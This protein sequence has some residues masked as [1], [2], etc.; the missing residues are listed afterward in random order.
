MKLRTDI[1]LPLL[2]SNA[3]RDY[4]FDM[5]VAQ[6]HNADVVA[7][8]FGVTLTKYI[9]QLQANEFEVK[10]TDTDGTFNA[11]GTLLSITKTGLEYSITTQY[12]KEFSAAFCYDAS[13]I[14]Q[15]AEIAVTFDVVNN[16]IDKKKIIVT[17]QNAIAQNYRIVLI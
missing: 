12:E 1:K 11:D 9:K 8:D 7:K 14:L 4:L 17:F 5:Q 3:K 10:A 16:I 13:G 2:A 15:P 6:K